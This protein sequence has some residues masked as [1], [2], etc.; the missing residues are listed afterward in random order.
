METNP[1]RTRSGRVV[2]LLISLVVLGCLLVYTYGILFAAPYSGFY[3][4]PS[5]GKI[6]EIYENQNVSPGLKVGDFIEKIGIVTWREYRDNKNVS[7]FKG[8]RAG[9][10]VTIIIQRAGKF[11]TVPWVY[12]GFNNT[13]FAKRFLN[14]WWLAYIFWVFGIATQIAMRPKD[15]RWRL[16]I[17]A[18]YLTALFIIFGSLSARQLWMSSSLLHAVAWLMLPVYIQFHWIF[19]TPLQHI[20]LRIWTVFYIVSISL[21]AAEIFLRPSRSLFFFA[22]LFA[23]VGSIGLL[24]IHFFRR[25]AQRGTIKIVA[26]GVVLA[27][28][29]TIV[30][31]LFGGNGRIPQ[32]G[33]LSLLALPIMP[34]TY[35]YAA[36]RGRLGGLELRSNQAISIYTFLILLGTILLIFMGYIDF[37]RISQEFVI[38][39]S[40]IIA[41]LTAWLTNSLFPA[42]QA[43]IERR[44]LGITLPSKNLPETYS[45]RITTSA[46]LASLLKLLEEEVFP[47]LLVKQYAFVQI[48]NASAKVMLSKNLTSDQIEE[49]IMMDLLGSSQTDRLLPFSEEDSLLGW[50]RLILPLKLE[51]NLMGAWLLG[52]RDPDDVYPQAELPILQSLA[53]QT[54]IALSNIVQTERL[55]QMY[56]DDIER[57]EKRRLQLALDLHDSVLNQLAIL[58][59]SVDQAHVSPKFQGAYDEVTKRLREIVTDLRPPMLS[60]GLQFAIEELADNL[61]ERSKDKVKVSA[62]VQVEDETRYPENVEQ[63]IFRMMQEAC[64]NAIRHGHATQINILAKLRT[65]NIWLLIEDNGIGFQADGQLDLDTLL[66]NK[67]FGLAGIVERAMIIGA[68]VQIDSSIE[69]GARIQISWNANKS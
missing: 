68:A 37:V 23:L 8:V 24:F 61:M 33:P 59:L 34:A 38:F 49:D 47:S 39:A 42:F 60:Y 4:N 30:V 45:A 57:N 11:V 51:T 7:F 28:L 44:V 21:A 13:E 46:S 14:I 69:V 26:A 32:I 36:F 35:F 18:D 10:V 66:A 64:E 25:P 43:F 6:L 58:R 19:P 2:D 62:N 31:S 65:G 29:P 55:R 9:D 53:D 40:I 12:P 1:S 17:S 50:V 27:V 22:V 5:D 41:M 15:L 54:A 16:L 67:H 20:P 63:H 3:F 52:R 56:T 48:K